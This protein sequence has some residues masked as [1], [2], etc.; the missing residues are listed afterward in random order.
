MT[1]FTFLD[2]D[3]IAGGDKFGNIF[4]VRVPGTVSDD[5]DNPTGS[6]LLWDTGILNGAPNKLE[7]LVQFHVGETVTSLHRCALVPGGAEAIIYVTAMGSLGALL[8]SQTREDKDFFSHLEMHMRQEFQPLTGRDH[9][10][11]RSYF[12]PVKDV[13]DG[14]LCELF[15]SLPYEQ[16]QKVAADLDR[17]PGEVIKKLE[18]TR[19]RLL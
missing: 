10:S 7:T 9:M 6:Q 8:P 4:I 19:N 11:Y 2:Y 5:I 12:A 17:S 13:A 15:T 3:T 18:D 14:E 1:S 16:Q